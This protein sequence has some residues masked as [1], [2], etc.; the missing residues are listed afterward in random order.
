MTIE[1]IMTAKAPKPAATS[2][3]FRVSDRIVS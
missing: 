2:M 3:L 1:S